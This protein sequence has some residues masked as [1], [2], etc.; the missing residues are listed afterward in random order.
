MYRALYSL[1]VLIPFNLGVFGCTTRSLEEQEAYEAIQR[2]NWAI[3]QL[4]YSSSK[5][6]YIVSYHE[7]RKGRR[8]RLFEVEDDL[9][10]NNCRMILREYWISPYPAD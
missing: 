1:I 2:E 10:K 4:A 6:A 9:S 5:N 7:H 3:C 8:H